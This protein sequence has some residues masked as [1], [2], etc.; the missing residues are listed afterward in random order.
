MERAVASADGAR[1]CG[2]CSDVPHSDV[3]G[4]RHATSE[5][6][7]DSP[8]PER[9]GGPPAGDRAHTGRCGQTNGTATGTA[10]QDAGLL[11]VTGP[12]RRLRAETAEPR[13]PDGLRGCQ[14]GVRRRR[15]AADA[16]N[17]RTPRRT[18]APGERAEA[19][20]EEPGPQPA[21]CRSGRCGRQPPPAAF[22]RLRSDADTAAAN[23]EHRRPNGECPPRS[24]ISS[25]LI[26]PRTT[27]AK[28]RATPPDRPHGPCCDAGQ[29]RRRSESTETPSMCAYKP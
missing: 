1:V 22:G 16:A 12:S 19:I 14:D 23:R 28:A 4:H 21:A 20:P 9:L 3:L 18:S 8:A 27:P 13:R 10:P 6:R 26:S 11:A 29:Q 15:A 5:H 2:R 25:V 24:T 17:M 7:R